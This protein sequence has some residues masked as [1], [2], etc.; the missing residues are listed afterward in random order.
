MKTNTMPPFTKED[1]E[2]LFI[3]R[4]QNGNMGPAHQQMR[5]YKSE[6]KRRKF[7]DVRR[8]GGGAKEQR[9]MQAKIEKGLV[10]PGYQGRVLREKLGA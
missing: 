2:Y 3:P 1:L 4:G 7:I 6:V 10:R 9:R 5:E 8:K